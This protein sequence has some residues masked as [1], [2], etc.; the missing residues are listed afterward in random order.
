ML[1]GLQVKNF[2][3]WR[4]TGHVRLAPLTFLFGT[5][6]SGKSSLHQ[7][8]LML[9][10]TA[11]SPDRRRVLHTGDPA[12]PVDLG[13]YLDLINGRDPERALEFELSWTLPEV[14]E[15]VDA[16]N[17]CTAEGNAMTFKARIEAV[18]SAPPRVH[19]ESFSYQLQRTDQESLTLGLKREKE[20][21]YRVV[22]DGYQP[23]MTMGRKWPVSTPSHFHAFPDDLQTRFQNLEFAPDLTFELEDQLSSLAYLGPLRQRPDRLYRWSGEEPEHVGWSGERTVE[24]LLAGQERQYNL[25][26]GRK[27]KPL[28]VIVAEWLKRLEVIDSFSVVPVG[29]RDAYEVRVRAPGRRQE[30]L[31]TD[32]GFGV[33]QVLPV[34]T[35]CFYSASH[36][37]LILEQPEIHLHPAVQA[38]L[39]DL[40]IE[41]TDMREDG[42]PRD[43][44]LIVESHSEHLL[45]RLLRRIAE[46]SLSPDDVAL[47]FVKPGPS[48][49]VIEPLDVD[50][51]GHVRNWP[52]NFFGD[53]TTD[54]LEQ[55]RHARR[56]R[57]RAVG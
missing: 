16:K 4:D 35:Q 11:E 45:R 17:D 52:K 25:K 21:A 38:G 48:A 42:A 47:Y 6:S 55:T 51:L 50:E 15:V 29:D 34:V 3:A 23:V 18:G 33:S 2:K 9:R 44:Q 49:S 8:L 22:S 32:V 20:N 5:N 13:G 24:A 19:V 7:F 54:M 14:L 36:S 12:T 41:A 28:Q 39:A 46:E 30:V 56:R 10:Q 31:L 43:L 37:T 40:F 1:T 27:L 57:L 26:P 53:Q